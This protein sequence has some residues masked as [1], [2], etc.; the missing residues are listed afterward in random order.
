MQGIGYDVVPPVTIFNKSC[1]YGPQGVLIL[2]PVKQAP[3]PFLWR[4]S[5]ALQRLG[6]S[7]M[8]SKNQ[9][10]ITGNARGAHRPFHDR[11]MRIPY[12][13]SW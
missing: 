7:L 10:R 12:N 13:G 4:L 9:N 5:E 3:R 11:Q 2:P 1:R 6:R 8:A